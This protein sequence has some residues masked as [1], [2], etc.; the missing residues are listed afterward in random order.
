MTLPAATGIACRL[1]LLSIRV[2]MSVLG[3]M[4]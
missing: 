3:F 1:L 2:S 4:V